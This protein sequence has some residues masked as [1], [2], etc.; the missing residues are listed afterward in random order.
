MT[1]F[2][3]G[4]VMAYLVKNRRLD[5]TATK[6]KSRV[7]ERALA[8][9]LRDAGQDERSELDGLLRGFGDQTRR[10]RQSSG[11]A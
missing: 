5:S 7:D 6:R 9:T 2:E 10:A 11:V 8:L 1:R 3:M 4:Q